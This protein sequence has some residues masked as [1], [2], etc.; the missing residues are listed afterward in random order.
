[1]K[2]RKIIAVFTTAIVAMSVSA[3]AQDP[4][5]LPDSGVDI[6]A[7]ITAGITFMGGIVAAAVAGFA[8]FAAIKKGLVWFRKAFG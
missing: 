8:I 4:V 6:P 3:M 7:Y 5:T 1:M 2:K